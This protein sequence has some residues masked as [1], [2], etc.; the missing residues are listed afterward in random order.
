MDDNSCETKNTRKNVP[1][2]CC[3]IANLYYL[4]ERS[5]DRKTNVVQV[6]RN[7]KNF[8]RVTKEGEMSQKMKNYLEEEVT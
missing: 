3:A 5:R 7:K 6:W 2:R 8:G 1:M 4:L